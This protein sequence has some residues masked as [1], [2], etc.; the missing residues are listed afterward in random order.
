MPARLQTG[1]VL[2]LNSLTISH[3]CMLLLSW[4]WGSPHV[5]KIP[6]RLISQFRRGLKKKAFITFGSELTFALPM[7]V[8]QA[9]SGRS[10]RT[11]SNDCF[12][13]QVLK[14]L[15]AHNTTT[16]RMLESF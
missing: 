5:V 1:A 12:N 2:T 7:V 6:N 16:N 14:C 10:V 8:F 15:Y 3:G 13:A 4:V 11:Y 9:T